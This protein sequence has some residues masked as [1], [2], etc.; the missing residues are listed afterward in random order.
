M[1]L[2]YNGERRNGPFGDPVVDPVVDPAVDPSLNRTP[3]WMVSTGRFMGLPNVASR[4]A[5]AWKKS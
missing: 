2:E 3:G 5:T 1:A 4:R